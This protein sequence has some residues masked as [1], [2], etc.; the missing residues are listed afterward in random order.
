M[1][2]IMPKYYPKWILFLKSD[3]DKRVNAKGND[4]KG[5]LIYITEIKS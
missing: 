1:P 5:N 3:I 4:Y 2:N